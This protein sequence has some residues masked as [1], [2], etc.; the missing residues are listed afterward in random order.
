MK[1]NLTK[2]ENKNYKKII[3]SLSGSWIKTIFIFF[4]FNLL[5]V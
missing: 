5:N 1:I 3:E 4:S 2:N